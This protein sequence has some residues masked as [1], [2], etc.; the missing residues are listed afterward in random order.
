MNTPSRALASAALL[1]SLMVVGCAGPAPAPAPAKK[2]PARAAAPREALPRAV[3]PVATVDGVA[4]TAEAFNAEV[5]FVRASGVTPDTIRKDRAQLV[6][7]LIQRHHIER[8][9]A[10]GEVVITT[11]E[12]DQLLA[13]MIQK[14]G[15][16]RAQFEA[17]LKRMGLTEADYRAR[18]IERLALARLARAHLSPVTE[19]D[20]RAYY[21]THQSELVTEE[22]V[23]LQQLLTRVGRDADADARAAAHDKIK[24]LHAQATAPGADFATVARANNPDV[25]SLGQF[26]RDQ[27]IEP[28][29]S[30]VFALKDGE[31]SAPV[32]TAAG[33]HVFRRARTVPSAPLTLEAAR[34]MIY[35]KLSGARSEAALERAKE[36]LQRGVSIKRMPENIR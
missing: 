9:R 24:A 8:A 31:V 22:K 21:D 27:L 25:W 1:L 29:S 36:A 16:D 19:E 23:E 11:A 6:D 26:T 7:A 28:I 30:V 2:T 35:T 14:I 12:V 32:Q 13:R 17:N 20:I 18:L 34:A 15:G 3:G 10:R 33:W 4:I 5:A